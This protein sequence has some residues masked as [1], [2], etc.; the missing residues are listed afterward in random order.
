MPIGT[1]LVRSKL[2]QGRVVQLVDYFFDFEKKAYDDLFRGI[3]LETDAVG[4]ARS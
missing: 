3:E 2:L 4:L 1:R